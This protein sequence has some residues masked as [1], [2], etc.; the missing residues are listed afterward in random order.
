MLNRLSLLAGLLAA[1][2]CGSAGSDRKTETSSV[3]D[4]STRAAAESAGTG[5]ASA[6]GQELVYV[7]NEDSRQLSVVD[8]TT[9]RVVATIEVGTRPRGV[10]PSADGRTIFVALSGSPKCP[11]TMPDEECEK[12]QADKSK[13]GIAVVD[14]G[15]RKLVRVLAGGSDPENFDISAD[16]TRLFVS[17]E[18]AGVASVV[19]IASGKI[20]S[21]VQVGREP[22]GVR[23][24]PDGKAVWVTGETDHNVTIIDAGTGKRLGVVPVGKRPRGI[25]FT[26]DGKRAYVTCEVDG[27]VWVIDVAG[28][29]TLAKLTLPGGAKPMGV[30]VAPDG[31]RVY[32]S[33]GRGGTV[34]VIDG[35]T[36]AIVGTVA[37]GKRPW[38][39]ALTR[40]GRKLYTANGPSNDVAVVDTKTL[41]VIGRIPVGEVPWG[42][43][44]AAAPGAAPAS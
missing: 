3:H 9:D 4:S 6:T 41:K 20:L 15:T 5:T 23:V 24:Q 21:S 36:N 35:T 2:A 12:L 10:H 34:A 42:V 39:I 7:T 27:T 37:V 29:K 28:R 33:T 1:T 18:D 8:A 22:E 26:P 14:A 32:V 11:P 40:D 38:G 25:A 13:D 31:G 19:E 44:V 30:V 43:A 17:N 16:G